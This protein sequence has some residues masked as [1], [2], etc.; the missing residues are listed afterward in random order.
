MKY[1]LAEIDIMR[2]AIEVIE[3]YRGMPH[4]EPKDHVI[5]AHLR[6]LMLN[7][8]Q[9]QELI[10]RVKLLLI[11]K[12]NQAYHSIWWEWLNEYETERDVENKKIG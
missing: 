5:E 4:R 11:G 7:G 3:Y 12:G 9:P 10:D 6:T 2:R 8:T 1:S